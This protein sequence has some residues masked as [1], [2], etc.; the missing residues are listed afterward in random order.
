M[1]T[2]DKNGHDNRMGWMLMAEEC[3]KVKGKKVYFTEYEICSEVRIPGVLNYSKGV[4][5]C[6]LLQEMNQKGLYTY[7]IRVKHAEKE[8]KF[9]E[10]NYSKEGYYFKNGLIGE[11]IALFSVYFQ[12]RFYLKATIIGEL[13]PR[14]IRLRDEN[15]FQYKRPSRFLNFE[16]FS[17]QKRNW[18]HKDGLKLFLDTIRTLDQE[19]HQSLIRAFYWYAEAI[20][21]IGVDRQLFFIKMV[22]AVEALLN[23]IEAPSGNLKVKLMKLVKEEFFTE[24]EKNEIERWLENRK[25]RQRF[26]IFLQN[27]SRGFFKKGKRKAKHCYIRKSELMNYAKRIYDAR[28]TY[29]HSGKPMFLSIDIGAEG[30]EFW[31]LDPSLG[32]MVDRKRFTA[33]EKLPRTRWFERLVNHCLKNFIEEKKS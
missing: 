24:A 17:E 11:L 33:N 28:S 26:M 19:Y 25:I 18:A 12:A 22:S 21:E 3:E 27:Y 8:Y 16:M 4:L 7:T 31:D 15:E 14:S 13:T 9:D 1:K 23:F 10:S 6:A 2:S 29:L 5:L 20:K 30:A 32:M